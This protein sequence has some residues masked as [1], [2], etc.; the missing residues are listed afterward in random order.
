MFYAISLL[1]I[2]LRCFN[3]FQVG[4]SIY[5]SSQF[6]LAFFRLARYVGPILFTTPCK[7]SLKCYISMSATRKVQLALCAR[8]NYFMRYAFCSFFKIKCTTN[9]H[10]FQ[11]GI[12]KKIQ[13]ALRARIFSISKIRILFTIPC[14]LSLKCPI[15][16]SGYRKCV[17]LALCACII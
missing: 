4:I 17:Q 9:C 10:V 13:L 16:T 15:F 2:F 7:Q 5:F 14:K 11:V 12:P 3:V 8:N 1:L 6:A